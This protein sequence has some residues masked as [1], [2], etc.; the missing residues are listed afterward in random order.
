MLHFSGNWPLSKLPKNRRNY[1]KMVVPRDL[2]P[3]EPSP[4]ICV[5][6]AKSVRQ[7]AEEV[8]RRFLPAYFRVL[9]ECIAQRDQNDAS[10]SQETNLA[11]RVA[12][13]LGQQCSEGRRNFDLPGNV[14]SDRGYGHVVVTGDDSVDFS[15][16]YLKPDVALKLIELLKTL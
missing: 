7:I 16:G 3:G 6:A 13:A 1:Q 11:G 9:A 14:T 10:E 12:A 5:S 2:R 15:I 8:R 4:S